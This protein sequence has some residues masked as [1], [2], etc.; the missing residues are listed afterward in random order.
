MPETKRVQKVRRRLSG[1]VGMAEWGAGVR[2]RGN[3]PYSICSCA[4]AY[5]SGST[6]GRGE[7]RDVPSRHGNAR[8]GWRQP[9]LAGQWM[10]R[11]QIEWMSTAATSHSPVQRD[12]GDV[13]ARQRST[14]PAKHQG[15]VLTYGH[16]QTRMRS[17]NLNHPQTK[18]PQLRRKSRGGTGLSDLV[19]MMGWVDH[20]Q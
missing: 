12:I 2:K 3:C 19:N 6:D 11:R 8:E 13:S 4:P 1:Q 7:C 17:T 9:K 15:I 14:E 18:G 20:S 10:A 16:S 5:H